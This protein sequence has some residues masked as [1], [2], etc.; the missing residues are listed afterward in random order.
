MGM[1]LAAFAV[2]LGNGAMNQI[3]R[4]R[5][6]E[7]QKEDQAFKNEQ[8]DRQRTQWG[9]EDRVKAGLK[10]ADD[11]FRSTL[12]S[13]KGPQLSAVPEPQADV[14][15]N[16]RPQMSLAPKTNILAD[17]N[18]PEAPQQSVAPQP[19]SMQGT[20]AVRAMGKGGKPGMLNAEAP[21]PRLLTAMNARTE[22][23]LKNGLMPQY[24]EAFLQTADLRAKVRA[25]EFAAADKEFALSGDPTVYAKRIYPLIEDG[26]D[27]VSGKMAADKDGR[28]VLNLV[29]RN[30]ET[31]QEENLQLPPDQF[32]RTVEI[33]RDPS[34]V[35]ASEAAHA[36]KRFETNE[37]IRKEAAKAKAAS[38][39]HARLEGVKHQNAV[40]LEGIKSSNNIKET[41]VRLG[42]ER[43]NTAAR[44]TLEHQAPVTLSE[45]QIRLAPQRNADGAIQYVPIAKGGAKNTNAVKDTDV[46]N[47]VI[48]NYG[49]DNPVSGRKT[50]N[51]RTARISAATRVIMKANPGL[52]A[53][54]A[55]EAAAREV[56]KTQGAK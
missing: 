18:A 43:A 14:L 17:P 45:G 37:D 25:N 51:E 48:N 19:G 31:G 4:N 26:H 54:Q 33:A 21:D 55:V 12:E 44:I 35:L 56:D 3:E 42:G 15:G 8:R 28:P 11:A 20:G 29:R 5:Q 50:G 52:D 34:A 2:G 38:E 40:T 53:N 9:D 1:G 46:S 30:Q 36:K 39:E 10:E 47:I 13:Y 22:V 16:Q 32:L 23:L 6:H 7:F 27:F 41:G 24:K 49:A